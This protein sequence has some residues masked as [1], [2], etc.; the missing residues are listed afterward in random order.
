VTLLNYDIFGSGHCSSFEDYHRRE[1]EYPLYSYAANNWAHHARRQ[2]F[3]QQLI[4]KFLLSTPKVA[5]CAQVLSGAKEA[6]PDYWMYLLSE[7][8]GHASRSKDYGRTSGLHLAAR[9]RLDQVMTNL[10]DN[11]MDIDGYTPELETPLSLAICNRHESTV[12]LLLD[13]GAS[14]N[15]VPGLQKDTYAWQQSRALIL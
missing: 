1:R 11:G 15:H 3:D 9:Y 2:P 12:K 10:L 14:T 7:T 13:S 8:L 6:F 4:L 5:A